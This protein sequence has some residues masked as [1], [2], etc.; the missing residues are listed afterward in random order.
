MGRLTAARGE[1]LAA[2]ARA[3]QLFV[4]PHDL[5]FSEAATAPLQGA[6]RSVR[7]VGAASFADIRLDFGME[8]H[9]VEAT[10]PANNPV[11]PGDRVGL[12][13][14]VSEFSIPRRGPQAM[15]SL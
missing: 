14:A 15:P 4:R 8:N 10:I 3:V 5:T 1:W 12:T 13:H 11:R 2:E 9:F 6:V 7:R